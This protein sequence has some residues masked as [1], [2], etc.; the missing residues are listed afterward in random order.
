V[1]QRL[2]EITQFF[3]G[4]SGGRAGRS[5]QNAKLQIRK[6]RNFK[7]RKSQKSNLEN[8]HHNFFHEVDHEIVFQQD[9]LLVLKQRQ[10]LR[11]FAPCPPFAMCEMQT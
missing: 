10:D 6:I 1:G 8:F 2:A 7:N 11:F 9:R 4:A 5:R 3:F